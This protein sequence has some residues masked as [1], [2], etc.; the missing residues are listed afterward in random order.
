MTEKGQIPGSY[1]VERVIAGKGFSHFAFIGA[2]NLEELMEFTASLT[3]KNP[4][5]R[6]FQTKIQ[7][8]RRVVRRSIVMPIKA[9]D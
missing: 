9:W 1:G 3:M 5:F 2:K 4:D 6:K 7:K 8:N